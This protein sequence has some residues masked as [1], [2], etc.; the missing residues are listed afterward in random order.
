MNYDWKFGWITQTTFQLA[1]GI[2]YQLADGL[3]FFA[4]QV[5]WA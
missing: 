1:V 5:L 4:I 2:S 3:R